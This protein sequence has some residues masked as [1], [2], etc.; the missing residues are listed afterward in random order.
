MSTDWPGCG[1][2]AEFAVYGGSEHP[3]DYTDA[4]EAH[5]GVMLGTPMFVEGDNVRWTVEVI[6]AP[7]DRYCC[8][9]PTEGSAEVPAGER[10]WWLDDY[11]GEHDGFHAQN[12]AG[13]TDYVFKNADDPEVLRALNDLEAERTRLE[14]RLAACD[15][16]MS[17]LSTDKNTLM[18]AVTHW[19]AR[20][21]VAEARLA[22][23]EAERDGAYRERAQMVVALAKVFPSWVNTDPAEPDWPVLY[24]QLPTGQASWHFSPADRAL[25]DGITVG[26][27]A[28]DGH[29]TEEKYERIAAIEDPAAALRAAIDAIMADPAIAALLDQQKEQG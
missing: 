16:E 1:K 26:G 6:T 2:A 12:R 21:Q 24:V 3:E 23:V 7:T 13:G 17:A 20:A 8:F 14:A 4:C 5:V 15:R 18:T 22:E 10:V 19:R 27:P 29:T 11:C 28:W 9:I 25:L